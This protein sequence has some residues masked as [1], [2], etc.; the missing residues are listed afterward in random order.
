M[1][2]NTLRRYSN[3]N[4]G[5]SCVLCCNYLKAEYGLH[6]IPPLSNFLLWLEQRKKMPLIFMNSQQ[7][8]GKAGWN[9]FRCIFKNKNSWHEGFKNEK[10]YWHLFVIPPFHINIALVKIYFI[11][12]KGYCYTQWSKKRIENILEEEQLILIYKHMRKTMSPNEKR[13]AC[14]SISETLKPLK[15]AKIN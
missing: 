8:E 13:I 15:T 1:T 2:I 4:Y 7:I 11:K 5:K 14:C 9:Q 6:M 10:D 12:P 3:F